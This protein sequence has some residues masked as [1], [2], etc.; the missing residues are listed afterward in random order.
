M[1]DLTISFYFF[2]LFFLLF[3]GAA[4]KA[5]SLK[6]ENDLLAEQLTETTMSLERSRHNLTKLQEKHKKI[7][8]FRSDLG[9]AELTHRAP[10]PQAT[11]IQALETHRNSPE[12]YNYVQSLAEKGLSVDEIAS[13]LTISIH[14]ARQVLALSKIAQGN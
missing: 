7:F 8:E 6:K 2:L 9:K 14:E 11:D 4:T 13:I 3:L 5:F 12:R 10:K 1:S